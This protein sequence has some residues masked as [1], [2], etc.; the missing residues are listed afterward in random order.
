MTAYFRCAVVAVLALVGLLVAPMA[1][2]ETRY[3]TDEFEVTMR[4]GPSL[5]NAITRMLTSGTAVEELERDTESGYSHVRTAGGTE[6]YVLTRFL[7]TEPDARSQLAALR[8]RVASLRNQSG[9]QGRELDDLRQQNASNRQRIQTLESEKKQL[10]A[11]L[12]DIR[13][14]AAET[15]R[16]NAENK[17]L[18][19]NLSEAE[20][21][22]ATLE[23]END[24]LV[25]R[26]EQNWFL[27]GAAVLAL[28][29]ILGIIAPRLSSSRRNRYGSSL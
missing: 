22:L 11:E 19:E 6:G 14:T 2:A 9:D 25:R 20:I 26:R 27:I 24:R 12:A 3:V 18:R 15:L 4:R 13:R 29:I 7:M 8:E 23:Q 28:G 10:E 5:Q 1:S 21:N 17:T 16:I